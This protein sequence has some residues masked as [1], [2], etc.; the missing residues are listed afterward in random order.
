MALVI[1]NVKHGPGH[2]QAADRIAVFVAVGSILAG[3]S[4]AHHV[5]NVVEETSFVLSV[6]GWSLIW[7]AFCCVCYLGCEPPLR[8][9]APQVLAASTRLLAGRFRDA[10]VGRDVLIGVLGG[11]IVV[12]LASIRFRLVPGRNADLVLYHAL[13]SLQSW[14]RFTFVEILGVMDAIETALAAA[15]LVAL[16]RPIVRRVGIAACAV[17][18]IAVPV[19]IGGIPL[20]AIDAALAVAIM[21]V[22]AV[23]F[24]RGGLLA[25]A[26]LYT[27]ER[28]LVAVPLT[29]DA[30]EWY[31]PASTITLALV[32]ALAVYAALVTCFGSTVHPSV[33]RSR[34]ATAATSRSS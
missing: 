1:R 8:R 2:R 10:V 4:R 19:T 22:D 18:L 17:A 31:F 28:F 29:L 13:E 34:L 11:V 25:L 32:I 27:V 14:R 12:T 5:A 23:V 21:L 6:S 9:H 16:V 20:S 15:L 7:A 26:T 33:A 3:I 24:V 30:G